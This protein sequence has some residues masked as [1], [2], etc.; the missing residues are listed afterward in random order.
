MKIPVNFSRVNIRNAMRLLN[1]SAGNLKI[2]ALQSNNNNLLCNKI[3]NCLYDAC[4][5]SYEK[6]KNSDTINPPN[7]SNCSSKHLKAIAEANMHS[8]IVYSLS[9]SPNRDP[10]EYLENWAKYEKMALEAENKEVN[11]NINTSW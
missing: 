4:K 1:T 3:S 6:H 10:L 11:T 7:L 2:E 5:R 8:Y 9:R